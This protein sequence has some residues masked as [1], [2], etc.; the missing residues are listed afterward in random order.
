MKRNALGARRI[1]VMVHLVQEDVFV[2]R[3]QDPLAAPV[4]V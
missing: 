1:R 4:M 2:S 3:H